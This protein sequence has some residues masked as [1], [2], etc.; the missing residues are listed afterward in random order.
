MIG[1]WPWVRTG[2]DPRPKTTSAITYVKMEHILLST[3]YHTT[4]E[5]RS[6]FELGCA[7]DMQSCQMKLTGYLSYDNIVRFSKC[8][9]VRSSHFPKKHLA[10]KRSRQGARCRTV[11]SMADVSLCE[12]FDGL[13]SIQKNKKKCI[14]VLQYSST[15]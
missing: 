7:P 8:S 5:V 13:L 10:I 15:R 4:W 3:V 1:L 11:F 12:Q 14:H 2:S 6:C 9:F